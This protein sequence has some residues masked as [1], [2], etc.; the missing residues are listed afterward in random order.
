MDDLKH[1]AHQVFAKNPEHIITHIRANDATS[2]TSY[3]ILD[4]FLKVKTLFKAVLPES[5]ETFSTL[6]I[7]SDNVKAAQT[8][9]NLCDHLVDLKMDILDN[10]NITGNHLG[11]KGLHL[12]KDSST[13]LAKKIYL[14]VAK[15]LVVFGT[16]K[17]NRQQESQ[18][19]IKMFLGHLLT[20]FQP[21]FHFYTP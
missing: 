12:N 1:L 2:S 21:M 8:V 13:C 10:R 4:K 6:T 3:E 11:R 15:I 18:I 20:H 14:Y 7:R 5:S 19:S 17:M 9:T 16:L